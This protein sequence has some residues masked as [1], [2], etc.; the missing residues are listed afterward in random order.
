MIQWIL[1]RKRLL[2][3]SFSPF[4]SFFFFFHQC[5]ENRK[6][7]REWKSNL[8]RA[9]TLKKNSTPAG[10]SFDISLAGFITAHTSNASLKSYENIRHKVYTAMAIGNGNGGWKRTIEKYMCTCGLVFWFRRCATDAAL[11][12][13]RANV[14]TGTGCILEMFR[15]W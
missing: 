14:A 1:H 11:L 5:N 10:I 12:L 7:F 2:W 4:Y 6:I 9:V 3:S 8:C 13:H 15:C